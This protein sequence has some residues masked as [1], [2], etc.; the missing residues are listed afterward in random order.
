[1]DKMYEKKGKSK[2]LMFLLNATLSIIS[3]VIVFIAFS[4][5]N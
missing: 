1:M 3:A 5:L 2:V 4:I